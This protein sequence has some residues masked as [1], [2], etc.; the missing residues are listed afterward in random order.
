MA[1]ASRGFQEKIGRFE[2]LGSPF[3]ALDYAVG[4]CGR[5][6]M[7]MQM[8]VSNAKNSVCFSQGVFVCVCV[9]VS[10][11]V[12][13]CVCVFVCMSVGTLDRCRIWRVQAHCLRR[14]GDLQCNGFPF[15]LTRFT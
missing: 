12:S 15:S 2:C 10:V 5:A 1:L 11:C 13:V 8:R 4:S 7:I 14:Y 9:C 6:V 3:A